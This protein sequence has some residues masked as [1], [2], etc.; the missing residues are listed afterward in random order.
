MDRLGY[1]SID[2]R[3]AER[4]HTT[5]EVLRTL[6]PDGRRAGTATASA[7]ASPGPT[8]TLGRAFGAAEP[9]FR[10]GQLVRVPNAGVDTCRA[11]AVT[12][13]R[14]GC[15]RLASLGIAADQPSA[16]RIVVDKSD[17]WLKAYG[18]GGKLLALFTVNHRLEPRPAPARR[19]GHQRRVPQS[20]LCLRPDL[21]WDVP[22][23]E[24]KQQL[25]PGPNGPSVWCGST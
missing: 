14:T 12:T 22:D 23:H 15:G 17:G 18:D 7:P 24:E 8:S 13:S 21:F 20:A 19:V 1:A 16:T 25:P 6:N 11:V 3:L 5:V 9:S 10:A 4:F 2:E